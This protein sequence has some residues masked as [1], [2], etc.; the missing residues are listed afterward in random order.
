MNWGRWSLIRFGLGFSLLVA[1]CPAVPQN[2]DQ[3]APA[4][5]EVTVTAQKR[6]ESLQNVPVA[7]TA[8]TADALETA[9]ID[10]LDCLGTR[11]PNMEVARQP[12]SAYL[13]FYGIR[14]VISGDT[15]SQVDG[16]DLNSLAQRPE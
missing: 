7:V 16:G 11:V 13:A 1:A 14:G 8:L 15:Q 3:N 12:S 9:R 5:E 4:L 2:K 10:S 6:E